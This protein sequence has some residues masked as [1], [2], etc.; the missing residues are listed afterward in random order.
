LLKRLG[1]R[2][3]EASSGEDG[4]RLA[5]GSQE[6]ISLLITD[7]LMPGMSGRELARALLARDTSLKVLFLSGHTGDPGVEKAAKE[8]VEAQEAQ[9]AH[10][11]TS[12]E[13][14]VNTPG[15]LANLTRTLEMLSKKHELQS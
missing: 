4:L 5:Q 12:Q 14:S 8:L 11:V 6:K 15:S 2:V 9:E 1:Y 3:Q 7:I 10:P 13:T